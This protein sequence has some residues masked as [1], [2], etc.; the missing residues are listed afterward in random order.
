MRDKTTDPTTKAVVDSMEEVEVATTM[1]EAGVD[2][3]IEQGRV[4]AAGDIAIEIAHLPTMH[5][6]VREG[7]STIQRKETTVSYYSRIKSF[8]P[9]L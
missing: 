6:P 5:H 7:K 2:T 3:V 4:R 8:I 9:T 1:E